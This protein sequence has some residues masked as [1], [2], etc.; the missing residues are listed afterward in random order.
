MTEEP[1][2]LGKWVT[3]YVLIILVVK[4]LARSTR[5]VEVSKK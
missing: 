2:W 3:F 5:M 4:P 1:G